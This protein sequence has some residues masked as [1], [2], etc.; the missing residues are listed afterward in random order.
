VRSL[1]VSSAPCNGHRVRSRPFVERVERDTVAGWLTST[2][3]R[4]TLE[5]RQTTMTGRFASS[6]RITRGCSRPSFTGSTATFHPEASSSISER[7]PEASRPSLALHHVPTHDEKRELYRAI[8]AALEP[9]GLVCVA[10]ALDHEEGPERDRMVEDLFAHM[11]RHGIRRDEAAAH[12]AQWADEDFYVSL[13]VELGLMN[14]AGFPRPDCF[15]R[16]GMIAV[17]GAFKDSSS[18]GDA[19]ST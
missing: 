18:S 7:E 10:D 17:Y 19:T 3:L 2:G 5:S 11:K 12:L 13:P 15:R 8:L 14:D 16:E 1:P 4:A 9:G 6:S